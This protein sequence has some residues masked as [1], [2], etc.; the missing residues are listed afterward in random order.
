MKVSKKAT[1]DRGEEMAVEFLRNT[2]HTILG[3]NY[4][5]RAGEIDIIALKDAELIFCEVKSSR[6]PGDSHP[7]LRVGYKKRIKI[8]R[9]ARH[10][11]AE[12]ELSFDSCRFD[13]LTVK[14]SSGREVI[15]HLKNAFWPPNGWDEE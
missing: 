12:N 9:V 7:E 5:Q 1:G 8:A 2:G 14:K 11:M 15:E 10:F 13:I 4:R 6:Y 3:R